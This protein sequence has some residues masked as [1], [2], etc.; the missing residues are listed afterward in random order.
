MISNP[1][2]A[3][4][5]NTEL[6]KKSKEI[7]SANYS[8]VMLP[9]FLVFSMLVFVQNSQE[10]YS[11]LFNN[12]GL[13]SAITYGI[14]SFIYFSLASYGLAS[15]GL[16]IA[17]EEGFEKNKLLE[18]FKV[19][20]KV[21]TVTLVYFLVILIGFL[22]L[23]IPGIVL[24]ITFSQVYFLILKTPE[25]SVSE[26]FKESALLMKGYKWQLF[27]MYI[28]FIFFLIISAFT[29]FIWSLWLIPQY[30]T[31]FALFYDEISSVNIQE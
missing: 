1:E 29:L 27:I 11:L 8:K 17:R 15:F 24:S 23:I 20:Q 7:L 6:L 9:F 22:L 25:K 3:I 30:Y 21:L 2:Q 26:L 31:A 18:G 13:Y 19:F 16:H 10:I 28:R 4:L 5:S 12:Y 14:I